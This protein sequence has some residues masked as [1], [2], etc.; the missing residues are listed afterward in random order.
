MTPLASKGRDELFAQIDELIEPFDIAGLRDHSRADWYPALAD[1][2]LAN[3]SKL[4]ARPAELEALLERC[5]FE[6]HGART[7][8]L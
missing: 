2:L 1:D 6:R 4:H 8:R 7:A 3:A 5:G